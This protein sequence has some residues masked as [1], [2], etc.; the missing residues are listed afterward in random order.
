[1]NSASLSSLAGRYENP[2]PP[3]CLA[4]IDFFKIPAL[5]ASNG[6]RGLGDTATFCIFSL[7]GGGRFLM[8]FNHLN[9]P[10]ITKIRIAKQKTTKPD[11]KNQS[12]QKN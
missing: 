10:P 5:L 3:Q 8:I 7:G 9:R 6:E 11:V 12:Q 4:P 2:I 1:M